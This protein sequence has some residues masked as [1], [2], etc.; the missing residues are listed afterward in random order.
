MSAGNRL[1]ELNSADAMSWLKAR[2]RQ[3]I[4]QGGS[5]LDGRRANLSRSYAPADDLLHVKE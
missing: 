5:E 4:Q 2:I 3:H 1:D